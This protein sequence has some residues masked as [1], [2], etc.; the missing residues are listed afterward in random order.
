M[1][2]EEIELLKRQLAREKAARLEAESILEQKSRELYEVNQHLYTLNRTLESQIEE[3]LKELGT[4]EQRYKDIVE[5]VGDIIYR[6]NPEGY[7][8]Y[9]NPVVKYTLGFSEEEIIG[10]H[11]TSFI[12][13]DY[14]K[15]A[16]EYYRNMY[17]E[18]LDRT[19]YRFPVLAKDNSLV[20]LGQVLNI[21]RDADG[22]MTELVAIAR[23]I[24]DRIKAE[25]ELANTQLRL[26]ALITNLHSAILVENENRE[27]ALTNQ[28]FCDMFGLPFTPDEMVG[29]S[30]MTFADQAK[31]LFENPNG[32][33]SRVDELLTSRVA[34]VQEELRMVDGRV[35]ERDFIPVFLKD[36]YLG[37]LWKYTDVTDKHRAQEQIRRSEEK[38]RGI[39][40]NMEL[41]LMEVDTNQVIVKVYDRFC[42]AVGYTRDELVGKSAPDLFLDKTDQNVAVIDEN[43]EKRKKGEASSY[44]VKMLK[45]DG[46]P[47]WMLISGAAI[48]DE[49]GVSTGSIGVHYDITDRKK[50]EQELSEAKQIAEE[51]RH[52][53]KQFLAN[54]SHE[55]RTPLNAIIG[56]T[57][58]LFDTRPTEEQTEYLEILKT[59]ST[60]LHSLISDLLDMA[61][62]EAGRIEVHKKE[63]DLIGLLRTSHRV[64]ELKISKR[65]VEMILHLDP[66]IQN[67]VVGDELLLNQ[68]LQNLVG[69]ADKFTE[70]G[71]ITLSTE[72]LSEDEDKFTIRFSVKD[73][74]TGI[75]KDK[76]GMIFQKFKQ[77]NS[78][79]HKH[80][81]TGLGLAIT[82]EL[83]D[84][85]GGTIWLESD[86]GKGCEFIF[87]LTYQKGSKEFIPIASNETREGKG[88]EMDNGYILVVED[89]LMNQKYISTLLKKWDRTFKLA[90]DGREA[91]E[92]TQKEKFDLIF[93]DIQMPHVDGYE[94]TIAIRSTNN[95]NTGTPIVALTASAMLDQKVRAM[96]VGMDDFLPKPFA[97][98]QLV[99]MLKKYAKS[100]TKQKEATV[101]EIENV[102][103]IEDDGLDHARLE[104]LYEDDTEYQI[105]MFETFLDD[106][107]PEFYT[108]GSLITER[109]FEDVGKLAH[110]LKPTFGMVGLTPVESKMIEFEKFAKSGL[111]TFEL[112]EDKLDAITS[113]LD[114][115]LPILRKELEKLKNMS[116]S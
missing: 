18:G 11:Y 84:I 13:P 70:K 115:K 21:I 12:H 101:V 78:H 88:N 67:N 83:I 38:Y 64:F 34:T 93:M 102:E 56:M 41:G 77:V 15:K 97:P 103:D 31:V 96:E 98:S 92:Y 82:K 100:D 49:N 63:F 91:I 89:N 29:M 94:A 37:H 106:V 57:H 2:N 111:A 25:E 107:L 4:S 58:L 80:K 66:K 14:R 69:N 75:P 52:A 22:R 24:T 27:I 8:V 55:I 95:F 85:Q 79:G 45:K 112:L 6:T 16:V 74:G 50:L 30:C 113:I 61:K 108:I 47:I 23:D 42:K 43:N 32:F 9:V 48:M 17:H 46:S 86:E 114:K 26:S 54:M 90:N 65:P 71:S 28:R 40:D 33:S 39:M 53:E 5:S 72:V 3:K 105:D 60:F 10:T 116:D 51:A 59:S 19:Y 109:N 1:I 62:I 87:V 20:W 68:I 76:Q 104:E 7:F 73:T 35:L 110:K 99:N 36:S 44:E 81:G